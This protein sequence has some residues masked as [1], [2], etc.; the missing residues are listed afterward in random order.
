MLNNEK[1][2]IMKNLRN[3]LIKMYQ[4]Q[5][6]DVKLSTNYCESTLNTWQVMRVSFNGKLIG[7]HVLSLDGTK[8]LN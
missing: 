4:S 6:F 3:E 5:G 8:I 1:T 2:R 7:G